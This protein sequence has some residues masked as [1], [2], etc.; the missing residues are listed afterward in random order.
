MID[1]TWKSSLEDLNL[2]VEL[3]AHGLNILVPHS[4]TKLVPCS[5]C[6]RT[7]FELGVMVVA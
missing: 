5:I 3:T 2:E 7:S 6:V 1:G 4:G